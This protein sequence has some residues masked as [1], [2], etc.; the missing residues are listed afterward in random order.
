MKR[1]NPSTGLPFKKGDVRED[2]RVFINYKLTRL[3]HDG[4]FEERWA[5][6]K[7]FS[8]DSIA[9]KQACKNLQARNMSTKDGH[10][11]QIL[12][13]VRQ[14]AK[15]HNIPFN[16]TLEYLKTLPSDTCPALGLSLN[17]GIRTQHTTAQSPSLDKINPIMGYTIGNVQWLSHKA[18]AM[19]QNATPSQLKQFAQWILL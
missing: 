13:G 14:R 16:L 6:E 1:L 7:A 9:R 11:K 2:G 10:M 12:K 8:I 17:W 4:L 3:K 15:Q 18:N 19:K 5:T